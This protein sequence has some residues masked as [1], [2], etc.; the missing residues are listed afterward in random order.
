MKNFKFDYDEENDDL[1]LFEEGK[2]SSGAVEIGNFVIDFDEDE[3][4]VGLEIL[5]AS[6]VLSKILSK[7]MELTKIKELKVDAINFRNMAAIKLKI[8]TDKDTETANI[9]IPKITEQIPELGY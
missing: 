7:V 2:K 1:F 4:F 5:D 6:E 9:L 3:N 8:T